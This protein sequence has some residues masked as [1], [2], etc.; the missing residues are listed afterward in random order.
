MDYRYWFLLTRL[1][2]VG[3]FVE[4]ADL[5]ERPPSAAG[6]TGFVPCEL[7]CEFLTIR[8]PEGPLNLNA[9]AQ[10]SA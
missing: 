5:G 6:E 7:C 2:F 3:R 1:W 4:V 10:D 9:D 8:G